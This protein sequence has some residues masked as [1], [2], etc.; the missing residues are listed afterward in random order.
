M[1]T[2]YAAAEQALVQALDAIEQTIDS[3]RPII[4]L[5]SALEQTSTDYLNTFRSLGSVTASGA[6]A[7]TQQAIRQRLDETAA[8]LDQQAYEAL[9]ANMTR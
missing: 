9:Q 7:S 2:A 3:S 1:P 4:S 5:C 8:T 6:P